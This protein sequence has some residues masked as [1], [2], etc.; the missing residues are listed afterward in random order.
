MLNKMVVG[1]VIFVLSVIIA[2]GFEWAIGVP[3]RK[4][5]AR[6]YSVYRTE[7]FFGLVNFMQNKNYIQVGKLP[8]NSEILS[9]PTVIKVCQSFERIASKLSLVDSHRRH[10]KSYQ[11]SLLADAN[12]IKMVCQS[13]DKNTANEQTFFQAISPEISRQYQTLMQSDRETRDTR[14]VLKHIFK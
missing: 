5:N 14:I 8:P 11:Q 3:T 10:A 1:G 7:Q 12:T 13:V 9:E 6:L 2:I 4:E